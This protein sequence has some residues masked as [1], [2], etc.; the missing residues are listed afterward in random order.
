MPIIQGHLHFHCSGNNCSRF[1]SCCRNEA[2]QPEISVGGSDHRVI[3][4]A[5]EYQLRGDSALAG[6]TKQR[7]DEDSSTRKVYARNVE[8]FAKHHGLSPSAIPPS[9]ILPENRPVRVVDILIKDAWFRGIENAKK[10]RPSVDAAAA[11]STNTRMRRSS[12]QP[13]EAM[14]K[15]HRSKKIAGQHIV[16]DPEK[17]EL[18]KRKKSILDVFSSAVDKSN[19]E[20][21]TV[22]W[23]FVEAFAKENGVDLATVSQLMPTLTAKEQIHKP[24]KPKELLPIF[25]FIQGVEA[26]SQLRSGSNTSSSVNDETESSPNRETSSLDVEGSTPPAEANSSGDE[27]NITRTF[28]S[29]YGKTSREKNAPDTE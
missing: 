28:S 22:M 5:G 1:S 17:K 27:S 19:R 13:L 9:L 25:S 14:F 7:A 10:S 26:I 21:R 2:E 23:E 12:I 16:W 4:R 15:D 20:T 18:K 29:L 24:L 6:T 3:Y 11:D 8:K